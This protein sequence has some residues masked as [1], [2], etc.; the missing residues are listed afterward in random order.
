MNAGALVGAASALCCLVM[1]P[2]ALVWG[3]A[4]LADWWVDRPMRRR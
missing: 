1:V 4:W 2:V 3:A